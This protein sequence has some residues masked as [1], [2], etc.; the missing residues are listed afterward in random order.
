MAITHSWT[1]CRRPAFRSGRKAGPWRAGRGRPLRALGNPLWCPAPS[2]G[3]SG[4]LSWT[5]SAVGSLT[6]PV[7]GARIDAVSWL[8]RRS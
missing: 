8:A 6:V 5:T 1:G 2:A 3:L 7:S 4:G